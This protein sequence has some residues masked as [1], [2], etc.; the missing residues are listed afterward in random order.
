MNSPVTITGAG[1]GG[2][3][4]ARVLHVNGIPS[5][6]YEADPSPAA[7]QQGGMLDIH[8]HNGQL[9]L[10]AADLMDEFHAVVEGRQTVDMING[11]GR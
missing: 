2:L 8:D 7:H 3:V 9:A 6:V 5:R 1:L 4:L 11:Q 10:Q